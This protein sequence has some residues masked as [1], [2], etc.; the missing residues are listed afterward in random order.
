MG[1]LDEII[2]MLSGPGPK[3]FPVTV[4]CGRC[5]EILTA[6]INLANDLSV[7]YGPTGTP[8]SYTCRKVLQ[9]GGRCFQTVEVLLTFDSRRSLRD[10]EIHGGTFVEK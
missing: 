3:T 1:V 6:R 8:Q 7:E 9:G 4:K 5:G 2:R 10:K